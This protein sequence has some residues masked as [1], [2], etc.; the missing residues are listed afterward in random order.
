MAVRRI[1]TALFAAAV[2]ACTGASSA[3]FAQTPDENFY[4]DGRHYDPADYYIYGPPEVSGCERQCARDFSP[5]DS[6]LM[7]KT[8]GRCNRNC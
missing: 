1:G 3:G 6:P 2:L 8:D 7:K 4:F 5:C